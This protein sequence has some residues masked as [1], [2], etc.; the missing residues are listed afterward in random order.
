M[1]TPH[2]TK[3]FTKKKNLLLL[4]AQLYLHL[5]N[6]KKGVIKRNYNVRGTIICNIIT[7]HEKLQVIYSKAHSVN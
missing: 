1:L 3:N 6:W 5:S 4:P 2:K 7:K